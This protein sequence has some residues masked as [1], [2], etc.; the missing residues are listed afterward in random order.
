MGT[1][2]EA[3]ADATSARSDD[4][5][6]FDQ[7]TDAIF[8]NA[9]QKVDKVATVAKNVGDSAATVAK[10]VRDAIEERDA[11]REAEARASMMKIGTL[12]KST[13]K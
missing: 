9:G 11:A 13:R 4:S 10:N 6:S 1:A 7:M 5:A 2:T 3:R 12:R 8:A